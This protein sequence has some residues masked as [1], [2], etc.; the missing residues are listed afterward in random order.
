MGSEKY[1]I[2]G[3][4]KF[5]FPLTDICNVLNIKSLHFGI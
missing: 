4:N 5:S 2:Q 1:L 3:E